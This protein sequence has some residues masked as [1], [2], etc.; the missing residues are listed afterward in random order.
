MQR[1]IKCLLLGAGLWVTGL[2]VGA[3]SC[4]KP[5]FMTFDTGHMGVAPLVAEVLNRHGVKV[6]FFL[7]NE[8]TKTGG[9]SLDAEWA[10][11]W[12]AR[13]AEGH[14]FGS[15][16]WDHDYWLADNADG[17]FRVR[18]SAGAQAGK[19]RTL[20]AADYCEELKRPGQRFAEMT[21]EVMAP[22]FRAP[23]GKTSKALLAAATRCG[24]SHV[25]WSPAGFLGDELPSD[26]YPNAMLLARAS[27][28]VQ[29][30][31]ILLA[32]LGLWD[33]Q[34]AWAPE[35]LEPLIV[36]LKARGICFATLREHPSYAGVLKV[37][38]SKPTA[39]DSA[40]Q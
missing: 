35:V 3:A 2:Q 33:R 9:T 15:H 6:T 16:T 36:N 4:E 7:A 31:D 20:S 11:W 5:V 37:V 1:D 21:G 12:K 18:A 32:H 8:A 22:L 23:G 10:S 24:F 13:V 19:L 27:A 26:K 29:P 17:S 34:Q 38:R 39:T 40:R 28:D 25:G 30:G 14:L